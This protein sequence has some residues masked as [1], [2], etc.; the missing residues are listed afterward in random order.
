MRWASLPACLAACAAI[1]ATH[2][3]PVTATAMVG[4][5]RFECSQAGV[6]AAEPAHWVDYDGTAQDVRLP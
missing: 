6:F 5:R 1:P 2:V 3:G 4:Q